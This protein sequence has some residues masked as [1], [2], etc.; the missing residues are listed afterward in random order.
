M[1]LSYNCNLS[2]G[3]RLEFVFE[4]SGAIY[5]IYINVSQSTG[6]LYLILEALYKWSR[7]VH[8]IPDD[9]SQSSRADYLI[10]EAV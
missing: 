4:W 8:V 5:K 3:I 2:K 10:T 7:T 1:S 6:G 9:A